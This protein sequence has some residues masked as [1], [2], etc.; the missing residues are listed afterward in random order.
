[1]CPGRSWGSWAP[2]VWNSLG[3]GDWL[4]APVA[5]SA[6]ARGSGHLEP[7]V[8]K[9]HHIAF[10]IS[11]IGR[12]WPSLACALQFVCS[13][14]LALCVCVVVKIFQIKQFIWVTLGC[15]PLPISRESPGLFHWPEAPPAVARG[16]A[17]TRGSGRA[18]QVMSDGPMTRVSQRF[19]AHVVVINM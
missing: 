12:H 8:A 1:M 9:P 5:S 4:W 7:R 19:H 11:G 13:Y 16:G 10:E 6:S 17:P 15:Q 18:W 3:Q 14:N 2:G